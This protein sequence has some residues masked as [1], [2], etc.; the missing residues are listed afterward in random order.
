[1]SD[2]H[3]PSDSESPLAKI[4]NLVM[5]LAVPA[6]LIVMLGW[7]GVKFVL[8]IAAPEKAAEAATAPAAA[9]AA[10]PA[11]TAPG[12]P[13][14][15]PPAAPPAPVAAA[16]GGASKKPDG[17]TDEFWALGKTTFATCQACHGADGQGLQVGTAKMAASFTKSE[18]LI[19]DPNRP[20]L[21]VLKG[22]Q[23]ENMDYLGVMAALGTFS[24]EQIAAVLTYCRNSFGN[25]AS[26]IT[27]EQ[28]A[29]ARAKFAPI[30][31]PAGV[32]RA[33]IDKILAETK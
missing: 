18:T 24:D 20:I 19:G 12:S 29:A 2:A 5:L 16:P 17:V 13:A 25:A 9:V 3:S 26:A 30:N 1:M 6:V 11:P 28:V 32:K 10:T 8:G 14:T 31:A 33:D 7:T 15:P 23:K 4:L 21:V 27:P 22:I